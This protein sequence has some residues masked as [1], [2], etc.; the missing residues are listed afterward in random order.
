LRYLSR[1]P[2]AAT[3]DRGDV[4]RGRLKLAESGSPGALSHADGGVIATTFADYR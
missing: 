3:G 1:P 4:G 2:L